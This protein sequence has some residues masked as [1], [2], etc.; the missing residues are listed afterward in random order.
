QAPRG[1]NRRSDGEL[2]LRLV[3]A[4]EN[5]MAERLIPAFR[6]EVRDAFFR[7]IVGVGGARLRFGGGGRARPGRSGRLVVEDDEGELHGDVE[8]LRPANPHR[9]AFWVGNLDGLERTSSVHLLLGEG[10]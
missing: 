10:E 5:E 7:E 6:N 8:I 4:L 2:G 9:E 1:R 3:D